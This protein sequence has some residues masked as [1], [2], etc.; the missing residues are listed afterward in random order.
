LQHIGN[1]GTK[2]KAESRPLDLI[3][4]SKENK[5]GAIVK[6]AQNRNN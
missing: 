1:N 5:Q 4:T 2:C 6:S 3:A